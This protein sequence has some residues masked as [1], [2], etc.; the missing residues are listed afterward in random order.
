MTDFALYRGG[1]IRTWLT[2]P[3]TIGIRKTG[4]RYTK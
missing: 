4:L 3:I 1:K 2:I